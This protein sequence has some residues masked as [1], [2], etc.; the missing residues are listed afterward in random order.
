MFPAKFDCHKPLLAGRIESIMAKALVDTGVVESGAVVSGGGRVG[1]AR[2]R[3]LGLTRFEEAENGRRRRER[4][5]NTTT[6]EQQKRMQRQRLWNSPNNKQHQPHTT[7][8]NDGN[9]NWHVKGKGSGPT[10]PPGSMA[11]A[12]RVKRI[13]TSWFESARTGISLR[14]ELH[15]FAWTGQLESLH[16]VTGIEPGVSGWTGLLAIGTSI[17]VAVWH[18]PIDQKQLEMMT[19]TATFDDIGHAPF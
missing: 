3:R 1:G 10:R 18:A 17:T 16:L 9:K 14:V 11:T 6:Q 5:V 7:R 19:K 15:E 8:S 2:R 13:F 12:A 4:E